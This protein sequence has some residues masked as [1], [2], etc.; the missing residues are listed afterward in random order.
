MLV[1][2]EVPTADKRNHNLATNKAAKTWAIDLYCPIISSAYVLE[3]FCHHVEK[4]TPSSFLFTLKREGG[5]V[6]TPSNTGK[7]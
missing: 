6:T 7:N 1:K 3:Y 5:G 2:P 4:K